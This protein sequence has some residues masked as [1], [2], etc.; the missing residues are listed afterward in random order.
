MTVTLWDE[1]DLTL[2]AALS[3]ATGTYGVWDSAV[4]DS[5]TWGPDE[6]WTDISDWLRRFSTTRKF[7]REVQ[8]WEAGNA[9]LVLDNLDGRFSMDKADGPY[10][11]NGVTGVRPWRPIRMTATVDGITYPIMRMYAKDWIE[12]YV[13]AGPGKGDA[14]VTVPCVDEMSRLAAVNNPATISQGTGE[15]FGARIHRWLDSAAHLGQRDIDEGSVTMQA[16]TLAGNTVTGLRLTA[17]SEGGA[18]WVE[19]DGTIVGARQYALVEENRAVNSQAIF[20]DGGAGEIPYSDMSLAA[21][22]DT[23]TNVAS[24]SR[25]GGTVQVVDDPTSRALYG[26]RTDPKTDLVCETDEQAKVLAAWKIARCRAPERRVESITVDARRTDV[27]W[28]TVLG[29][30]VRDLVTVI[31]RPPGGH[32]ITQ[33]CHVAGISH[34]VT[35]ERWSVTFYLSSATVYR[36]FAASRWDVGLWGASEDDPNGALWFY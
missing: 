5:A 33:Y 19:A 7:S 4:W 16:T 21:P 24:Y 26:D 15:L 34:K 25:A 22:G 27:P 29:L 20:G 28:A 18:V 31:R 23:I 11:T 9:S 32:T 14:I 12:S 30:R 8:A 10:V 6:V 2:E 1:V 35:P 3:A 13:S 17:D 36:R